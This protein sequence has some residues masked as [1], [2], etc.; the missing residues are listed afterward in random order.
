M[1]D[2][3]VLDVALN[4]AMPYVFNVQSVEEIVRGDITQSDIS[5]LELP[6]KETAIYVAF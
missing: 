6:T 2:T 1:K 5:K 3:N 4:T